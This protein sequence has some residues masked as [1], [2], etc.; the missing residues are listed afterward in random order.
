MI[1]RLWRWFKNFWQRL[2]GRKQVVSSR[3]SDIKVKSRRL[4]TDAEYESLF[5]QLLDGVND[6]GWSRGRVNAFLDGNNIVKDDLLGWLR[7]FG[8][9]LLTGDGENHQLA[10]R[11]VRLSEVGCGELGEVAGEIGRKLLDKGGEEEKAEVDWF[12]RGVEQLE[13]GDF[14]GSLAYFD[15]A[16]EIK[17][18][19]YEAWLLPGIALYELGRFD[20]AI[21]SYDKAVEIKPDDHEAWYNRGITLDKLGKFDEAIT[22]YDKA[23]EIKSDYHQ[24]WL[25][26]GVVLGNLGR[27]DESIASFDKAI[28]IKPDEHYAWFNRGIALGKLGRFDQAIQSYDKA[29]EIKPDYHEAWYTRGNALYES[30]RF[31]EAIASYDKAVEIKPDYHQAWYNRG[32]AL[33]DLGRFNEA[34]A[35]YDKAIEIK[36]DYYQAWFNRGIALNKLGRFSETI[37]SYDKAVEIKPDDHEAWLNRGATLDKLGR[38]DEA[39]ASYDKAVEIKPDL[40]QAWFN[41]GISAGQS[42]S[43]N[44]FSAGYNTFT[45]QNPDLNLRGYQGELASYQ[46]GLK[47]C[48]QN[49]HPEGWGILHQAIGKA[50]Y[51]EGVGKADYREYWFKAEAEYKQALITL[52]PEAFPEL[53]LKVLG[54]LIRVLF[55]LGKDQEAKQ[56]RN[57][58][59]EVFGNLLNSNKSS[60]QK[61]KLEAEFYGFSQMR[62]DVLIEDGDFRLALETAERNKNSYLTWILD[63]QKETILSPSYSEI[64]ELVNPQ[65]TPNTAIIYW[66]LSPSALTTFII[67]P[68]TDK[69]EVIPTQ[70]SEQLEA[71]IKNWDEQYENYGK[72]PNQQ[73]LDSPWRLNLPE[74][75]KELSQILNIPRILQSIQNSGDKPFRYALGDRIQNLI[76]IPHRDLHRFPLHGLFPDNFTINYLPSAQ[77]GLTLKSQSQNSHNITNS[78]KLL[79]VEYS[80]GNTK[81]KN[82]PGLNYAEIESETIARIFEK[83]NLKYISQSEANKS[84]VKQALR[85]GY[86]IFH[87]NGHGSYDN[88]NPKNSALYLNHDSTDAETNPNLTL[89]EIRELDL[90]GYQL[91]SLSACETGIT[92]KETVEAEY[93]GLVSAFVYQGVS[94]VVSSLWKVNEISTSLLMIY[95]Y[96]QI[97]KGKTPKI[98]LSTA[99]QWLK[100]LT[101]RKLKKYYD[102]SFS[103]LGEHNSSTIILN[104]YLKSIQNN[105]DKL[106]YHHPYYWSGFT[107]TGI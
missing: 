103:Q 15:K 59:L 26:R 88:K 42:I 34:I 6:E 32:N 13:A 105:P 89:S 81:D 50:H 10:V 29:V 55:G 104:T 41:R 40:Y 91:V 72:I 43:F 65:T 31:D 92:G 63:A 75:L 2:F 45:I 60:L 80:G 14:Q 4:L 53:H 58:G 36:P 97:R 78:A 79:I 76:L 27:F 9:R 57:Q 61:R 8:E 101:Y 47:Y 37:A 52:T 21:T 98:A 1:K 38:F 82:S 54:N 22:S 23:V 35:F 106:I 18:D 62:V 19:F 46:E 39:I 87:F 25:F 84:T 85:E 3:R 66:H 74:L 64:Q 17:A 93:V 5:L 51:Y 77:I 67:K 56:W 12:E 11:M 95:F 71:W 49:T 107:V 94:H 102:I 30:G 69:P 24:A 83:N 73:L 7:R 90:R 99:R 20:E 28:E 48:L 33:D 100:T 44:Q 68:R 96:R 16:I 70:K 86:N